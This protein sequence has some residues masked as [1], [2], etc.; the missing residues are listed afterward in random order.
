M[1]NLPSCL[2]FK[3][4][5]SLL[6]LTAF[7]SANAQSELFP[8]GQ[9][10]QLKLGRKIYFDTAGRNHTALQRY[11]TNELSTD[12]VSQDSLLRSLYPERKAWQSKNW[13]YRKLFT[14]HLVEVEKEDYSFYLDFLPDMQIGET[15]WK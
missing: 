8:L 12:S 5:L 15:K 11:F 4:S 2:A 14:E 3:L 13:L 6:F 7:I 9:D 1:N 10:L